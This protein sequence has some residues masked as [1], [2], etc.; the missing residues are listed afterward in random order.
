MARTIRR[1]RL[2][3]AAAAVAAV[4]VL[5]GCSVAN[6]ITT[7]DPYAPSDGVR[8]AVTEFVSVENLMILTTGEG[9][10]GHLLGAVVNRSK[11]DVEV[12]FTFG[13]SGGAVPVRVEAGGTVNFTDAGIT[14]ESVEAAP[15]ANI[16]AT[17][18]M[19]TAGAQQV[20]VPVLDGTIPPYGDYLDQA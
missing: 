6:P 15:G 9:E 7:Q 14:T 16:T 8:V 4:L 12:A 2:A 10:E 20:A 11:E 18:E 1:T 3:A 13:E 17:V 19:P 5:A